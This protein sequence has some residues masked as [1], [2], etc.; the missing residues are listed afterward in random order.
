MSSGGRNGGETLQKHGSLFAEGA[1]LLRQ[2]SVGEVM[3]CFEMTRGNSERNSGF[4]PGVLFR[5][6]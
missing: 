2:S 6:V 4:I 3:G 1:W 5:A